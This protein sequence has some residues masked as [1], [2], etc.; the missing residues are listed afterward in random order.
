MKKQHLPS[1]I[2]LSCS[3]SFLWRKKWRL[4]WIEVKYCSQKCRLTKLKTKK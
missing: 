4:N 3:R 1:K 2:C